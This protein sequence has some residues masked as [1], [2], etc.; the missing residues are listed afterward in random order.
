MANRDF[1]RKDRQSSPTSSPRGTNYLL[2]NTTA[3]TASGGL[4][5]FWQI[6]LQF[7]AYDPIAYP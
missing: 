7:A 6:A 4:P 2:A 1:V 5:N 3:S